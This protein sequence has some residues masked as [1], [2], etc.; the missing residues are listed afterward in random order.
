MQPCAV[1]I[2]TLPD[3]VVFT[4]PCD[5][6]RQGRVFTFSSVDFIAEL[7][8]VELTPKAEPIKATNGGYRLPLCR[9]GL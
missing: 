3:H 7:V 5:P 1:L 2:S 4:F 6:N 9:F 8:P